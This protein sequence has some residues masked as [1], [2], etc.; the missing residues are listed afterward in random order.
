MTFLVNGDVSGTTNDG[1][2]RRVTINGVGGGS[3]GL[4]SSG[5]GVPIETN[6]VIS[7]NG[8]LVTGSALLGTSTESA[9][10][11]TSGT[12]G[13]GGTRGGG[14]EISI[15]TVLDLVSSGTSFGTSGGFARNTSSSDELVVSLTNGTGLSVS[16]TSGTVGIGESTSSTTSTVLHVET[17]G[18]GETNGGSSSNG[19]IARGTVSTTSSTDTSLVVESSTALRTEVGSGTGFN[20]R[21]ITTSG[22]GGNLG[23]IGQGGVALSL[24]GGG[25]LGT[26]INE[27]VSGVKT[28]GTDGGIGTLATS[29]A[30]GTNIV[31]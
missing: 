27:D 15:S 6:P 23:G 19:G 8:S 4:A 5:G 31:N 25:N 17:G 16:T 30:S 10:G 24:G 14:V 21:N 29:G 11:V 22:V 9:V 7:S 1:V 2:T 13:G 28:S 26:G 20:T 12:G 3:T 18:T